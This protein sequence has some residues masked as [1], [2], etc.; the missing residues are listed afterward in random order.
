M[1]PI[2]SG[3]HVVACGNSLGLKERYVDE[4]WEERTEENIGI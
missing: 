2:V 1:T 3:L 4:V